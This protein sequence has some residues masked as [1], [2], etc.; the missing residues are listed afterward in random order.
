M[1]LKSLSTSWPVASERISILIVCE[2]SVALLLYEATTAQTLGAGEPAGMVGVAAE[3]VVA[4][5]FPLA[6][7]GILI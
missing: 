3:T 6:V 4:M 7:A 5:N 1:K 2:R